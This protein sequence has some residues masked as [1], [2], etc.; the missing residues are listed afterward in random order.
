MLKIG[1][2][3]V[4][5]MG[6]IHVNYY[7]RLEKEGFPI[8][9]VAM[10]DIRKERLDG[11]DIKINIS[12]GTNDSIGDGVGKY[13]SFDDMIA[14]EELDAIDVALPTY[15][16]AEYSIKSM[17]NGKHV[18]CEKPMAINADEC[19]KMIDTSKRTDKELMIG[20]CLRFW[21]MYAEVKR[22]VE[23]GRYGKVLCAYFYRGGALPSWSWDNWMLTK[24]KSGGCVLDQHVH[25]VDFINY[26]FGMPEYVS[27]SGKTLCPGSGYDCVSTNY[28][29][30]DGMVINAQDDWTLSGA[31]G[32]GMCYR[33]SFEKGFMVLN[34]DGTT[35]FGT[36]DGSIDKPEMGDTD[37]YYNEMKYFY[38]AIM[39]DTPIEIARPE[40]TMA[41][42]R[43]AEAEIKSA[44]KKGELVKP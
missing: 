27:S 39:N 17:E 28:H 7:A 24:E 3:G 12:T 41:S 2:V 29:Y 40:S 36:D 11:S 4:G 9:L 32:F 44:D 19:Q 34:S 25:D 1:I 42:V 5:G 43:I 6:S 15:L 8:K 22:A 38:N 33:I 20:Q 26:L 14:K 18:F 35:M 37:G 23:D 10:C 30:K 31:Y 21:P 13:T 16:H